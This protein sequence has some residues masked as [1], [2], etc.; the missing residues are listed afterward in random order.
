MS[1]LQGKFEEIMSRNKLRKWNRESYKVH[2]QKEEIY[3]NY[4]NHSYERH[5]HETR[6]KW[7]KGTQTQ[8][9]LILEG[10]SY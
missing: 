5:N 1:D 10:K 6:E 8:D 2:F 3:W 9:T 7:K 4:E